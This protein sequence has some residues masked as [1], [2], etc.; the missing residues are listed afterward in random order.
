V[1]PDAAPAYTPRD[2]AATAPPKR[3]VM[4]IALSAS[5][6]T[7]LPAGLSAFALTLPQAELPKGRS[8]VLQ[9]FEE[10][11]RHKTRSLAVSYDA[12]PSAGALSFS[13]SDP[14]ALA[15]DRRYLVILY[16]DPLAATPAPSMA[17]PTL[18]SALPGT[19]P[20]GSA[21]PSGPFAPPTVLPTR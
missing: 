2:P 11:K 12:T 19:F 5:V 21:S 1:H 20:T 18:P 7:T 16:A 10:E 14:L 13:G 3:A 6:D 8:F 9:A 17:A 15:K 4:E